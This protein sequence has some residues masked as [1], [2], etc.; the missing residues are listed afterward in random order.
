MDEKQP[1]IDPMFAAQVRQARNMTP[2]QRV[3]EGMRLSDLAL[4]IMADGVR[5]QFPGASEEDV[6][7]L[8]HQRMQRIRQ[9]EALR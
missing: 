4:Q 7:R 3:L 9:L 6:R 5:H 2:E 8:V 1:Q